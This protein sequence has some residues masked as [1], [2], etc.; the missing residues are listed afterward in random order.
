MIT[1]IKNKITPIIYQRLIH[2]IASHKSGNRGS[3]IYCGGANSC[4]SG[5]FFSTLINRAAFFPSLVI[6]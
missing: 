2:V 1:Q 3:L 5:I 6:A 4:V